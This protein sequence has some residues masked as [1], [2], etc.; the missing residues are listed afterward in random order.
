[1]MTK[2]KVRHSSEKLIFHKIHF[3]VRRRVKFGEAV[4]VCGSTP[5]LGLWNPEKAFR[6]KWNEVL[7]LRLRATPGPE[8]SSLRPKYPYRLNTSMLLQVGRTLLANGANG[9]LVGT[10]ERPT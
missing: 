10:T 6:L 8:P 5:E 4:Y 2:K 1:M 3:T 7:F 9:K